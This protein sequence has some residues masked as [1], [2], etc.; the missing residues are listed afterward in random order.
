MSDTPGAG[1]NAGVRVPDEG[2]PT[3][4]TGATIPTPGGDGLLLVLENV[5]VHFGRRRALSDVS[6]QLHEG[7]LV[8][9]VGNDGAGKT[10]LLR[11]LAGLVRP[12]SGRAVRHVGKEQMGYSGADFDLYGDLTVKENLDFFARVRGL[13]RGRAEAARNRLLELVGLGEARDRLA[14]KLSGG[15]KKKLGLAGALLHEPR[16]LLLDEPT[17]GVDPASRRELWDIVAQANAWGTAVVFTTTYLDEAERAGR[18]LD[19]EAGVV[20][21]EY[22]AAAEAVGHGWQAWR[23]PLAG[24]RSAVRL[25]LY[26]LGLGGWA[27]LTPE[28]LTILSRGRDEAERVAGQVFAGEAAGP[29]A[30]MEAIPLRLEDV[31]VLSQAE[32]GGEA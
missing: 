30:A 27:Y 7:D 4:A 16:L 2:G 18:I 21:G 23:V 10:T 22:R 13:D 15:M 11:L 14:A 1:A 24:P 19:M 3:T 6:L 20:R 9:I 5:S 25:R 31:F 26:E 32:G 29:L 12:G 28:G 8:A 17:L